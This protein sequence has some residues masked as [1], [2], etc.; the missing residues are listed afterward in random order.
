M[1]IFNLIQC[2]SKN[3]KKKTFILIFKPIFYVKVLLFWFLKMSNFALKFKIHVYRNILSFDV[4]EN[5]LCFK[6]KSMNLCYG[7]SEDRPWV[8]L[9]RRME[10]SIRAWADDDRMS[11]TQVLLAWSALMYEST[12]QLSEKGSTKV[13]Q[14]VIATHLCK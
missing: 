5:A 6:F 4:S 7:S 3:R 9:M 11:V 10:S 8:F 12:S 2:L 14:K 1:R 13:Y